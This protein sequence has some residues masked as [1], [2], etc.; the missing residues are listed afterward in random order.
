MFLAH[1]TLF[2]IVLR[3]RYPYLSP[4]YPKKP[5]APAP[6]AASVAAPAAA[7]VV[8]TAAAITAGVK[9]SNLIHDDDEEFDERD[10][11]RAKLSSP[12]D[13]GVSPLVSEKKPVSFVAAAVAAVV[14]T[15]ATPVEPQSPFLL[16]DTAIAENIHNLSAALLQSD[17]VYQPADLFAGEKITVSRLLGVDE[18]E[19]KIASLPTEDAK[20]KAI[21]T[22]AKSYITEMDDLKCFSRPVSLLCLPC[23][24]RLSFSPG[25]IFSVSIR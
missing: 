1:F 25:L 5:P 3:G 23:R 22:M 2:F 21:Y 6:A 17:G 10:S 24:R 14:P 11:K 13:A 9:R 4:T 7:P 8:S 20:K 15:E 18:I 19:S 16:K 12:S